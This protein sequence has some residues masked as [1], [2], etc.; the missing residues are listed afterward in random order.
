MADRPATTFSTSASSSVASSAHG[1]YDSCTDN[2]PPRVRSN[3]SVSILDNRDAKVKKFCPSDDTVLKESLQVQQ[4][5]K[6]CVT[7]A[8]TQLKVLCRKFAVLSEKVKQEAK[9]REDAEKEVR[10]LNAIIQDA[11]NPLITSTRS[12]AQQYLRAQKDELAAVRDELRRTKEELYHV[13]QAY[14]RLRAELDQFHHHPPPMPQPVHHHQESMLDSQIQWDREQSSRIHD[15]LSC[16]IAELHDELHAKEVEIESLRASVQR[17]KAK[18]REIEQMTASLEAQNSQDKDQLSKVTQSLRDMTLSHANEIEKLHVAQDTINEERTVKDALQHQVSTLHQV[19]DALQKRC[20]ALVRRHQL[21][22]TFLAEAQ[23]LKTQLAELETQHEALVKDMRDAKQ[24]HYQDVE[25]LKATLHESQSATQDAEK[26]VMELQGELT[27]VRIQ[28]N[29]M[30]E[31]MIYDPK[32]AQPI[33]STGSDNHRVGSHYSFPRISPTCA[34]HHAPP[35]LPIQGH[36]RA[37]HQCRSRIFPV[38]SVP[39]PTNLSRTMSTG[40]PIQDTS[41]KARRGPHKATATPLRHYDPENEQPKTTDLHHH[42]V[43]LVTDAAT[44]QP[45]L[46]GRSS[47]IS[48]TRSTGANASSSASDHSI[49]RALKSRNKQ[50]QERLQ[51]EADATFQLEEEIN[52]ITSSYHTLLHPQDN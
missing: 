23:G 20:D 48:S 31:Y 43:P 38:L 28:H 2:P 30:S 26:R 40:F 47:T 24:A 39:L 13:T 12:D 34:G 19:N 33:P 9:M 22:A 25:A 35:P 45:T 49:L 8:T 37:L 4:S 14:D 32:R 15:T 16:T 27:A 36:S 17:E 18:Q 21:N 42:S 46:D 51:Q 29:T 44:S 50:L 6:T 52:M 1:D 3:R 41:L 7:T 10:R 5:S 11:T